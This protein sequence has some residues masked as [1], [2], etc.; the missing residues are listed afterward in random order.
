MQVDTDIDCKDMLCEKIILILC[1]RPS[2]HL[3]CAAKEMGLRVR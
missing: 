1:M 2:M 3:P